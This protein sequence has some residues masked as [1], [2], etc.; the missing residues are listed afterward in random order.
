MIPSAY[1]GGP[2]ADAVIH[3]EAGVAEHIDVDAYLRARGFVHGRLTKGETPGFDAAL[4]FLVGDATD[5]APSSPVEAM[6]H[7]QADLIL[8][9]QERAEPFA[10]PSASLERDARTPDQN[11]WAPPHYVDID[12]DGSLN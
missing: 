5:S 6:P 1:V 8:L 11:S 4:R 12:F 3:A 2:L 7:W 10:S 9:P